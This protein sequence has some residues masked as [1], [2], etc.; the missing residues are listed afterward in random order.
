MDKPI[1]TLDIDTSLCHTLTMNYLRLDRVVRHL[2]RHCSTNTYYKGLLRQHELLGRLSEKQIIS[3]EIQIEKN[4]RDAQQ[5][6]KQEIAEW[7]A[8]H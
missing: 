7:N 5:R 1:P 3:V 2:E 6:A 8:T 4:N